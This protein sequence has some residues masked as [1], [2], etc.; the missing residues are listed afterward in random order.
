M[1]KTEKLVLIEGTFSNEEGKDILTNIF[2]TKVNFHQKKNFSSQER[3]GKPDETAERR[4]P[5]LR[6]EIL[7]LDQILAEAKL[8]NAKVVIS[9]AITI[10]LAYD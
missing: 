2:S 8:H 10:S 1:N 5:E 9:S 3:F 6:S 4:I 7:K